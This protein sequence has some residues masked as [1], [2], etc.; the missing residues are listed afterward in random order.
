LRERVLVR[1]EQVR[2][3]HGHFFGSGCFGSAWPLYVRIAF[4][5]LSRFVLLLLHLLLV[6]L[7][8]LLHSPLVLSE[9]AFELLSFGVKR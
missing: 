2:Q 1:R 7:L 9:G 5:F 8:S 6:L 4:A 3:A